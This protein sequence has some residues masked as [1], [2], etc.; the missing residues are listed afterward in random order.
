MTMTAIAFSEHGGPEVLQPM[1]LPVP[2]PGPGEVR[3]RIKAVAL[4]HLDIWVRKGGPAFKLDL[5]HRL[6]SDI[7]GELDAIGV[8]A[9]PLVSSLGAKVVV[10]PGISRR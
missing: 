7:V 10:Q 6:G 5:P 3:V 2:E 4:N 9:R 1:E 8:G